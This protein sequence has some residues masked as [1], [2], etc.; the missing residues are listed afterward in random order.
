MTLRH[1]LG[2][3]VIVLAGCPSDDASGDGTDTDTES[4]TGATSPSTSSPST[5]SPSTSSSSS[6]ASTT[7]DTTGDETTTG[8]TSTGEESTTGE[9]LPGTCLGLDIV[10]TLGDVSS[11]DGMD[12][13]PTCSTEPAACGGDV[14]GTWTIESF[15]VCAGVPT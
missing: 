5:S 14:V 10:G 15:V 7:D 13:D 8:D 1:A 11:L 3:A 9:M 4:S 6:S 2:V 12:I